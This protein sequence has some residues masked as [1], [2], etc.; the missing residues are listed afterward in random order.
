MGVEVFFFFFFIQSLKRKLWVFQEGFSQVIHFIVVA[1]ERAS[2][3][4]VANALRLS[5]LARDF[6]LSPFFPFF[7]PLALSFWY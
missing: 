5:R 7:L 3:R 6:L 4:A 2:N 1:D